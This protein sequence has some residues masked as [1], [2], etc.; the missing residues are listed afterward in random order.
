MLEEQIR[1][2]S[3]RPT[4]LLSALLIADPELGY[5]LDAAYSIR[6]S[7]PVRRTALEQMIK[8]RML[9]PGLRR[10]RLLVEYPQPSEVNPTEY[11]HIYDGLTAAN[12][13]IGR[14][15]RRMIDVIEIFPD[16]SLSIASDLRLIKLLG[17]RRPCL[18]EARTAMDRLYH[19]VSF[20][21]MALCGQP[22]WPSPTEQRI[23]A[24]QQVEIGRILR[25][26]RSRDR[27]GQDYRLLA[28]AEV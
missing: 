25:A 18:A 13:P 14:P 27:W 11:Y 6:H 2:S 9:K 23:P 10:H 22:F 19:Q 7:L 16:Y 17:L 5:R 8:K 4:D 21:V 12:F 26:C 24:I 1:S 15:G 28:V 3:K 20:P